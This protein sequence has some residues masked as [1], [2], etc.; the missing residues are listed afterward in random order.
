MCTYGGICPFYYKYFSLLF[1]FNVVTDRHSLL[2]CLDIDLNIDNRYRAGS[3]SAGV[4]SVRTVLLS[5][6][7]PGKLQS[8]SHFPS[9]EPLLTSAE[10]LWGHRRPPDTS[11]ASVFNCWEL[12]P[13]YPV[14]PLSGE[15]VWLRH[16]ISVP[17][18]LPPSTEHKIAFLF[19]TCW[20]LSWSSS[21]FQPSAL[22]HKYSYHYWWLCI[23]S[24]RFLFRFSQWEEKR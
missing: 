9:A 18:Y 4:G 13:L 6:C 23:F 10:N 16:I 19:K 24:N 21:K 17:L 3:H 7:P 11:S 2:L 15:L 20:P 14:S 8:C 5:D 12:R 22:S 1:V